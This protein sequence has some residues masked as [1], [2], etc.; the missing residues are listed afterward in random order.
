MAHKPA[1]VIECDK[2]MGFTLVEMIIVILIFSV[3]AALAFPKLTDTVEFSRSMEALKNFGHIRNAMDRC[4][5]F[6][7]T[8]APCAD[9]QSLD[10]SDPGSVDNSHFTYTISD[11]DE[12][13][14][15]IVAFRNTFDS[16]DGVS[17]ITY[18]YTAES[19]VKIG[20]GAFEGI[21]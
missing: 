5:V 14:F 20:T 13:G 17:T 8:Y 18:V 11:V 10:I 1:W 12:E 19:I 16:G 3:L 6:S 9:I 15:T 21:K 2:K 7:N 4:F